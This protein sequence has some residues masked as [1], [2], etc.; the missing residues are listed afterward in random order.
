MPKRSNTHTNTHTHIPLFFVSELH[1][2]NY[3][4]IFVAF[5]SILW[6]LLLNLLLVNGVDKFRLWTVLPETARGL[7]LSGDRRS[8][9]E[10]ETKF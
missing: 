3:I 8:F 6:C 4:F 5:H 9:P 7:D 10:A 1:F 2:I